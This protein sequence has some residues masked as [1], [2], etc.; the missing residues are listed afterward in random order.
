MKKVMPD[1]VRKK[2]GQTLHKKMTFDQ[3]LVKRDT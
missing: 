2:G 1:P 3:I